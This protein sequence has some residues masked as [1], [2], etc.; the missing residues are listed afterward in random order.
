MT[1]VSVTYFTFK[2]KR[3]VKRQV[4]H[5]PAATNVDCLAGPRDSVHC[6]S[7]L[8]GTK[9]DFWLERPMCQG[10]DATF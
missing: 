1:D 10:L 4:A 5:Q 9:C 8:V 7:R 6:W 2:Y 3:C